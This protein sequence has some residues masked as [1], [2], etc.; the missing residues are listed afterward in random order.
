[1]DA[2]V[3]GDLADEFE[4]QL[5][6]LLAE[7]DS[8][9][10]EPEL[11]P[12][13]ASN[14]S[15]RRYHRRN[16]KRWQLA[17][18][19]RERPDLAATLASRV[20][21]AVVCDEDVAANRQL[22]EPVLTAVGRRRVQEYLISVV[23]SGPLLQ[24]VCAVRAWYWSQAVLVYESPRAL[25]GGQPTTGSQAHDDEVADL[26]GW[27]RAA[28]LTA[29]VECDHDAT[30]EW[31]ARG[32]ILDESYYPA[33]L[34]RGVAAAR[35]IAESDP[36]RFKELIAKTTDGTNLAAIRPADDH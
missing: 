30:R 29:F 10:V 23:T 3:D 35:A 12:R 2:W 20:L 18:V 1:M 7:L 17:C 31:L 28:C 36:A 24:R 32:F 15:F 19:L 5:D 9:W 21:A 6:D 25:T 16:G 14:E 8:A 34:H 22:I 13:F 11:Q 4:R 27:Y 26:R 33:S